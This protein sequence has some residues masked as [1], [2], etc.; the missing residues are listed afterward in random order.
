MASQAI[1]FQGGFLR[2]CVYTYSKGEMMDKMAAI[3]VP[4]N[5]LI[6]SFPCNSSDPLT[7]LGGLQTKK[8]QSRGVWF[9]EP[10]YCEVSTYFSI[11]RTSNTGQLFST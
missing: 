9:G 10:T 3:D 6:R 7:V 4:R 8:D 2:S 5:E 1:F 11:L